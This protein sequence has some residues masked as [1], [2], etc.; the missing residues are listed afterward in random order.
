MQDKSTNDNLVLSEIDQGNLVAQINREMRKMV[1]DIADPNKAATKERSVSGTIKFKPNKQR[2][3]A[4]VTYAVS[5]KP[6]P[7]AASEESDIYLGKDTLGEPIARPHIPNQQRMP[8]AEESD[9][10]EARAS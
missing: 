5:S 3:A 1:T 9:E 2:S 6:A 4:A 7:Y 8:F 10:S